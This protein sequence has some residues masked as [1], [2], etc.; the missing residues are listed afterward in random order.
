MNKI[1]LFNIKD[2][3]INENTYERLLNVVSDEKRAR[4]ARFRVHED[5][6]RSLFAEVIAKN[7]L[8]KE[9]NCDIEDIEFEKNKYG[10][11]KL[12]EDRNIYFNISHSG[13]YA[14]VGISDSEVGID[15]EIYKDAKHEI[16]DLAKRYYTEDEYNW[17]LSFDESERIKAFYKIW[18]L[19]E[20]YVKFAGKGLSISLSSFTFTVDGN[21]IYLKKDEQIFNDVK[22]KTYDIED[23][24]MMS[25]CYK[26]LQSSENIYIKYITMEQLKEDLKIN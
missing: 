15:I 16:I 23:S 7:E 25:M 19:K 3:N 22:F 1:Y 4:I 11:L 2:I 18:T 21:S 20:S 6:L 13:D 9:L 12:K 8:S 26:S 17:I 5:K 24:Y 10:K 14:I